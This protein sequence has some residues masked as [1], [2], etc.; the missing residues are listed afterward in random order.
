MIVKVYDINGSELKTLVHSIFDSGTHTIKWDAGNLPSGI[1][2]ISIQ[3]R[4]FVDTKKV[5]LIKKC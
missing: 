4:H 3:S 2:F 5:S 1:Y